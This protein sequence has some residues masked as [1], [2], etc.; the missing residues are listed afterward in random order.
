MRCG[1]G[2]GRPFWVYNGKCQMFVHNRFFMDKADVKECMN[3]LM[4]K[5]CEGFDRIPVC[6]FKD[7]KAVCVLM[8]YCALNNNGF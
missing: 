8:V 5:K 4:N 7:A 6:V 2:Q 1:I 3:T